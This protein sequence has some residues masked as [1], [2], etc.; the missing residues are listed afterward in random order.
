MFRVQKKPAPGERRGREYGRGWSF[1]VLWVR[2]VWELFVE[3]RVL[4]DPSSATAGQDGRMANPDATRLF[5]AAHGK[6]TR[7]SHIP[8]SQGG[9]SQYY[10][11]NC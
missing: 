2:S 3:F 6:A 4:N 5:A 9:D 10:A 1:A 8:S 11:A 7:S